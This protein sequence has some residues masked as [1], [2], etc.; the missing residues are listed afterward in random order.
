MRSPFSFQSACSNISNTTTTITN[1][2]LSNDH[3]NNSGSGMDQFKERL[4]RSALKQ[5]ETHGWTSEAITAA[6][7][8]DPK[9]SLTMAGMLTPTELLHWFMDDMNRQLKNKMLENNEQESTTTPIE[10]TFNAIQ[11]RLRQVIPLVENGQWHKGMALGMSTPLTTRRQL[12]DFICLVAP[13]DASTE[14][15]T[16]LGG[17]FVATE[18][19]LLTDSSLDYQDTWNFLRNALEELERNKHQPQ[20][21]Q[22]STQW[23]R[24]FPSW[25]PWQWHHL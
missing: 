15:Q 10:N 4:A 9:L 12:H 7:V 19:H 22:I 11:W 23:I 3:N 13:P 16:A 14:Y 6:A 21:I 24:A 8:Q 1:R 17:I 25:H 5:V 2:H 18:L 20:P